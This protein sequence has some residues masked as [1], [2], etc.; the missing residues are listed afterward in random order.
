M[1]KKLPFFA[2]LSVM[3][4]FI[5]G[6]ALLTQ[7]ELTAN[8][9]GAP[10]MRTG[11]PGD[12]KSCTTCHSG[13]AQNVAGIMTSNVPSSGYVPGVTYIIDAVCVDAAKN[14]FGFEI[15]PQ[16]VSGAKLGILTITDAVR[17]K[18]IGSGKY[19]THTAAGTSGTG[20]I[21]WSFNWTAPPAG[22]GDV[23]FYGAFNFTNH[24]NASSGDII[25]LSELVLNEDLFTGTETLSKEDD[26]KLYPNP[27]SDVATISI[28]GINEVKLVQIFNVN[29]DLVRTYDNETLLKPL[30][31]NVSMLKAGTYYISF[32]TEKGNYSRK[33]IKL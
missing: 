6:T 18:L 10:T 19:I 24:N 5:C 9:S 3:F 33:L 28:P 23:T 29:G 16:S 32:A 20:S 1:R 25:K 17:T 31:L 7:N 15:S 26:I 14:R 4:I 22:T 27:A 11:S 21:S 2:A 13:T 30:Q 12:T 8:N